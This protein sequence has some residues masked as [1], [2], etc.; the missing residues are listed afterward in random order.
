MRLPEARGIRRK[1]NN[2][3]KRGCRIFKNISYK[4]MKADQKE[5]VIHGDSR[6][7]K[8]QT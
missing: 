1:E 5:E 3:K 8:P 7:I 6:R 2:K 4:H